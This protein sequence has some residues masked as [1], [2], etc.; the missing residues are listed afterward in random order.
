MGDPGS[1]ALG[2]VGQQDGT[3]EIF[4]RAHALTCVVPLVPDLL[5]RQLLPSIERKQP[6]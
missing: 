4:T 5:E 2:I 1:Q 6:Q 3:D